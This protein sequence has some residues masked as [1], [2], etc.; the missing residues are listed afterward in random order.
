M[1]YARGLCGVCNLLQFLK[2]PRSLWGCGT[3]VGYVV[4]K[5]QFCAMNKTSNMKILMCELDLGQNMKVVEH[6]YKYLC[7]KFGDEM[8]S[9]DRANPY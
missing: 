5:F 7:V 3:A 2:I 6:I 9:F 8:T 1:R 4:G